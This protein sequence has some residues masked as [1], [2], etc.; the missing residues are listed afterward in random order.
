MLDATG[1][2]AYVLA[3]PRGAV[4]DV[5]GVAGVPVRRGLE[6]ETG[7]DDGVDAGE[8]GVERGHDVGHDGG[9][10]PA[11]RARQGSAE[12]VRG[13]QQEVDEVATDRDPAVADHAEEVLGAVGHGDDRIE[14]EHARRPLD[15]V[16]VAEERGDDPAGRGV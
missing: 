11:L 10:D 2:D 4:D 16:G 15:R 7:D 12:R 3:G 9:R 8:G 13:H 6:G 14:A 1:R 5:V